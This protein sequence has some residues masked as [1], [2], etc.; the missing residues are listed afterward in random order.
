MVS[1]HE[2][3]AHPVKW[4]KHCSINFLLFKFLITYVGELK[5]PNKSSVK[6]NMLKQYAMAMDLTNACANTLSVFTHTHTHT[7]THGYEVEN[8]I[9]AHDILMTIL[10]RTI[11]TFT[12]IHAC[13]HTYIHT[14]TLFAG[15]HT[16]SVAASV[17][18]V[19][20]VL[21]R[22]CFTYSFFRVR[23]SVCVRECI[24]VPYWRVCIFM[25]AWCLHACIRT[26]T[27]KHAC[28][29]GAFCQWNEWY[30][31]QLLIFI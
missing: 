4:E 15:F 25:Y 8:I 7:H 10:R 1:I 9:Y 18:H 12:Y 16:V 28:A 11:C 27:R 24:H 3:I 6:E 14:Y 30:L 19:L 23:K 2:S 29:G 31:A 13:I 5:G 17:G 22:V 21:Y 20:S 26:C